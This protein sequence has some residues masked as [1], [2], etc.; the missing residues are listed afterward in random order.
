MHLSL[1]LQAFSIKSECFYLI[2]VVV[3]IVTFCGFCTLR[4]SIAFYSLY[5]RD[6]N[7]TNLQCFQPF[8]PTELFSTSEKFKLRPSSDAELFMSRT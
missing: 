3:L 5:F 8:C 7:R 4:D 6:S 1:H 2:K